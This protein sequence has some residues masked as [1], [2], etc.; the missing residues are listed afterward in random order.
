[1]SGI[2]IGLKMYFNISLEYQLLIDTK[3]GRNLI[4]DQKFTD[5][6]YFDKVSVQNGL[7]H[8]G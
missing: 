1:M 3:N 6:F 7:R 2:F 5:A 8:Y 4:P